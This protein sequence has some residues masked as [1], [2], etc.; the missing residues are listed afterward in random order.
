MKDL[1]QSLAAIKPTIEGTY[2]FGCVD[3]VAPHLAPF[4][5]IHEAEGTTIVVPA[6]EAGDYGLSVQDTFARLGLGASTALD[7]VGITATVAQTLASR[8]IACNVIA[9]FYHDHVFVPAD[10]ADEA[11]RLLED[12]ADQA[13]GWLPN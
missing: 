12:L 4:A 1:D 13:R 10:Q 11:V 6:T 9:G 8:G 5:I 2:I 7:S 3:A